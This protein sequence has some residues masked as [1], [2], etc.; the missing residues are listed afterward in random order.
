VLGSELAAALEEV[1]LIRQL[2]P[3][4]NTR[5]PQ[6]ERYVYLRRR[7]DQ[8]VVSRVPSPYGPLRRRSHA[9]R[10]ARALAGCSEEEYDQLLEG[11]P[12]VRLYERLADL[13]DCL[14]YEDAARL[15]DRIASL[16][17][18]IDQLG[19]LDQLRRLEAC[20]LAPA[21]EPGWFDAFFVC[22]GRIVNQR[23]LPPGTSARAEI[24]AALTTATHAS[25][26][27]PSHDP[28]HLD[29]LLVIGSFLKHPPP[30]LRVLPLDADQ[31]LAFLNR[32][33]YAAA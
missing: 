12:L 14:R 27:G 5:K 24:E 9:E 11:A 1:S 33:H 2:R 29:E 25:M 20:A 6:P 16:E 28:D 22:A 26:N 4:A 21:L 30:E 32:P 31:I 8:V 3:P 23:K 13:A 18:V 15:R 10:A 7:G 19:R 17:R